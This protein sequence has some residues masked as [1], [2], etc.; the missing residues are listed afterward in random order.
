M[1]KYKVNIDEVVVFTERLSSMIDAG[2]PIIKCLYTIRTQEENED[3]KRIIYSMCLDLEGGL[4]LSEALSKYPT[5]FSDFYVNLVRA[6]ETGGI[7]DEVLERIATYLSKQQYIKREIKKAFAYPTIV[8]A[9]AILIVGFLTIFIVPVFA[10]IYRK[11]GV[12]LPLPTIILVSI[13]NIVGKYW[14]LL[15]VLSIVSAGALKAMYKKPAVRRAID[16]MKLNA[17]IFG[18][19]NRQIA[20]SR[21][22][23]TLAAL[24]TSGIPIMKGLDVVKDISGNIVFADLMDNI[25]ES[26]REG[27]MISDTLEESNL[28]PPMVIQMISAGEVSGA[29]EKMLN[30]SADFL[31]R[32]IN[33]TIGKLVTR[34]EPALTT[35]LAFVIGFIAMAIYLPMF[36][37]VSGISK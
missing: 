34:L 29:L 20:V 36:D 24:T 2:L 27:N 37:V 9:A 35:M 1:K 23:R 28:F 21:V 14:L 6:G 12:T 31:D 4:Q 17:P 16:M 10:D 25:K 5:I 7:L 32:D 11:M 13:S 22:V 18:T 19:L 15:L 8:L 33:Y 30:K 3:L 26:V